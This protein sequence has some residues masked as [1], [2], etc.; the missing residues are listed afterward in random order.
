[1]TRKQELIEFISSMQEGE[2]LVVEEYHF[3][4]GF[5]TSDLRSTHSFKCDN[6]ITESII[7]DNFDEQLFGYYTVDSDGNPSDD[8]NRMMIDRW[9]KVDR[10]LPPTEEEGGNE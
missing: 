4:D 8:L 10:P 1:M 9:T 3:Y 6:A 7:A 2:M 5:K